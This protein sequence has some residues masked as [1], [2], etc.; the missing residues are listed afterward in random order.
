MRGSSAP[1]GDMQWGVICERSLSDALAPIETM[2]KEFKFTLRQLTFATIIGVIAT[3]FFAGGIG[4]LIA[5]RTTSPINEMMESVHEIANGNFS[6]KID[7]TGPSDIQQLGQTIN[8]MS[9]AI[10]RYTRD[11]EKLSS[12]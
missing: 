11:L 9:D 1:I 8:Y 4:A 2:V 3:A 12:E 10:E 7:V 5:V 6:N